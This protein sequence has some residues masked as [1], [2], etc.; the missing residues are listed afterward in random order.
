[1]TGVGAL[2]QELDRTLE[3]VERNVEELLQAQSHLVPADADLE[4]ER[5]Y[6]MALD[7]D[8]R[9]HELQQSLQSNMLQMEQAEER[10][11]TGDVAQIVR[12]LHQHQSSLANLEDVAR[13]MDADI[14]QISRVFAT[15]AVGQRG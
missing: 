11:L 7:L 8:A 4:R 15:A 12:V 10:A 3:T 1:L 13:R 6:Q 5:A 9:L 14:S 2:Q